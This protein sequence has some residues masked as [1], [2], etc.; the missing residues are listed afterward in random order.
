MDR[1]PASVDHAIT[2][3]VIRCAVLACGVINAYNDEGF[4]YVRVARR[5]CLDRFREARRAGCNDDEATQEALQ[6]L[7]AFAANDACAAKAPR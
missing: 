4:E 1:I 5:I 6:A 2:L 3:A 7:R